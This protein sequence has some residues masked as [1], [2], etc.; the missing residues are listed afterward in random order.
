V[1]ENPCVG[2]VTYDGYLLDINDAPGIGADA[3]E[4]FLEKC[5]RFTV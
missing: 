2:G 4:T 5:E 1:F 3:N